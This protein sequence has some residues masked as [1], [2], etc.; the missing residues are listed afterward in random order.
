MTT[1]IEDDRTDAERQTLTELIG[2]RDSFM[3]GWGKASGGGSFAFWACTPAQAADVRAW[4]V[5]RDEFTLV[6]F[7]RMSQQA[8]HCHIYAVNTNDHAALS[9]RCKHRNCFVATKAHGT[10]CGNHDD[11][12]PKTREAWVIQ[13][14]YGTCWEDLTHCESKADAREE[15]K[16]YDMNEP[17]HRHRVKRRMVR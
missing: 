13:G 4:V 5:S 2:G 8:T 12:K 1:T 16:A 9:P 17:Q 3:S 10:S 11:D 7:E 14:H 15:L 6:E